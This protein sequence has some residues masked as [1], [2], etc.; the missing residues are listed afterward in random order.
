MT[1]QG[2]PLVWGLVWTAVACLRFSQ[3]YGGSLPEVDPVV[4]AARNDAE[5]RVGLEKIARLLR[6]SEMTPSARY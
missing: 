2:R 5:L 4:L 1:R 6:E 3:A